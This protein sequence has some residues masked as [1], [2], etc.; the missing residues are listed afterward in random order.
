MQLRCTSCSKM[1]EAPP[2][3]DGG[4]FNCPECGEDVSISTAVASM[5]RGS[6][7]AEVPRILNVRQLADGRFRVEYHLR[8][9]VMSVLS[10]L[11]SMGTSAYL[12][13]TWVSR[14][15]NKP[16]GERRLWFLVLGIVVL[17]GG[18]W[19]ML[20]VILG[21]RALEFDVEGVTRCFRLPPL[22]ERRKHFRVEDISKLHVTTF[23]HAKPGDN[24]P[25]WLEA[26]VNGKQVMLVIGLDVSTLEWIRSRVQAV[27]AGAESN[28]PIEAEENRN[29][30]TRTG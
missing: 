10:M 25:R 30:S 14:Y 7:A 23:E 5:A 24:S 20:R 19:M 8:T 16:E 4:G 15:M 29:D 26:I 11:F 13:Y 3:Y 6:D 2:D 28:T 18:I 1:L 27:L 9:N 22:P 17:G 21:R 12:L